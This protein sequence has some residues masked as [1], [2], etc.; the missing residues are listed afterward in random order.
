MKFLE[1]RGFQVDGVTNGED[2]IAMVEEAGG[3]FDLV[4][5]DEMMPGIDGLAT[6]QGIK[7]RSP[8][9]PVIMVT[10]SEDEELID[11]AIRKEIQNY[12]VKPV[13]PLQVYTA[14]KQLLDG[15]R[16]RESAVMRDY[17]SEFTVLRNLRSSGG[18][19]SAWIEVHRKLSEWDIRLDS[20]RDAGLLQTHEDAKSEA[21]VEFGQFV[22]RN[23]QGWMGADE[24]DRPTLSVD[25]VKKFVARWRLFFSLRSAMTAPP[26]STLRLLYG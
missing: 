1:D 25:I 13:N 16:I 26:F 22:S 20:H 24:D 8:Y 14:A 4:I 2:A 6:L 11:A 15:N 23:Y 21:N 17:V 9:I 7:E 3:R 5:L 18:D 12:L 19:S 10:K